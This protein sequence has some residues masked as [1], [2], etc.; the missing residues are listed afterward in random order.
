MKKSKNLKTTIFGALAA[1]CSVLST[2]PGLIGSIGTAGAALFTFFLG[3][4][5]EDAKKK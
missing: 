2:N 3:A 1:V 5:A 4:S